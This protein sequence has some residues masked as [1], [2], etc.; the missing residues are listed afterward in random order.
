MSE[1]AADDTEVDVL[2][3]GGGAAGLSAAL[4]AAEGGQ[5]VLV[6]VKGRLGDGST[7]WAQGGLAAVLAP[8]DSVAAHVHDTL[9]AGAGLC[10]AAA[11]G[12]LVRAAPGAVA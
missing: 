11:V 12:D 8:Q 5:R 4:A 3:I 1:R 7:P 10:D 9:V 2:V 6:A